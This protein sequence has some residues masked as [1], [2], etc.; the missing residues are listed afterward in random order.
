MA[1]GQMC[2]FFVC[3]TKQNIKLTDLMRTSLVESPPSFLFEKCKQA[4]KKLNFHTAFQDAE[5]MSIMCMSDI[6]YSCWGGQIVVKVLPV[7]SS[8]SRIMVRSISNLQLF[9]VTKDNKNEE[10]LLKEIQNLCSPAK[11]SFKPMM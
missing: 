2:L 3:N 5:S 6:T 1:L 9:G 8:S 11:K 10:R 7:S 4:I